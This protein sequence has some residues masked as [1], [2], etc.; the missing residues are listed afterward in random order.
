MIQ[1][2]CESQLVKLPEFGRVIP[3]ERFFDHEHLAT[4]LLADGEYLAAIV[5]D[6]LARR[7]LFV[8]WNVFV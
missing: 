1:Y 7:E 4:A 6:L 2:W 8:C 3:A 5:S